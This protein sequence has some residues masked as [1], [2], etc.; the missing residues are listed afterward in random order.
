[1]IAD[2]I[3][4]LIVAFF[5]YSGYKAGLMKAFI[6]IASYLISIVVSFFLY[7]VISD[8]LMKTPVYEKLFKILNEKYISQSL[9]TVS[10]TNM[11]GILPKYVQSGMETAATGI[12]G[13]VATL[14]I[15]ILAFIII[16]IL[17]KVI[18][19]ITGNILGIFTKMPVIK[20]FNRL[21]GSVI[22]GGVGILMLYIISAALLLF[23]PLE[24]QSYLEKEIESSFFASEICENNIIISFLGK[25][26]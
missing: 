10:D 7:P 19:R 20:Q 2:A 3:V 22:G 12:A 23:S 5:V 26:K 4:V 17:S 16:L 8:I 6:K 21:G 24:T 25:G 15:N 9:T 18:I 11:F 13:S 1:M 14:L